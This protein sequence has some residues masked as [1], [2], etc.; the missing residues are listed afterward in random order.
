ML[1]TAEAAITT[2]ALVSGSLKPKPKCTT[3]TV[4]ACPRT[5]TQRIRTSFRRLTD[6]SF[7][8]GVCV[9]SLAMLIEIYPARPMPGA[10][11]DNSA[12]F[13][14]GSAARR[15]LLRQ[16]EVAVAQL[17]DIDRGAVPARRPAGKFIGPFDAA[18]AIKLDQDT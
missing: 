7:G 4:T 15:L 9:D 17:V 10:G 6:T 13:G 16:L 2:S 18:L 5:A 11:R 12:F 14:A 8:G 1:R 3:S